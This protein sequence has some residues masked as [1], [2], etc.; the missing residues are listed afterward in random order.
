[1]SPEA[2]AYSS[3]YSDSPVVS[4]LFGIVPPIVRTARGAFQNKT[5]TATWTVG[6]ITVSSGEALFVV[7]GVNDGNLPSLTWGGAT[8]VRNYTSSAFSSGVA[9]YSLLNP[10]PGT[11]S[12]VMSFSGTIPSARACT[13]T[14]VSGLMTSGAAE[15]QLVGF[16]SGTS[17]NPA[18][19]VYASST[20]AREF[21]LA[22][23]LTLG[24]VSD[25]IGTATPPFSLGQRTGTSGNGAAS[26]ATVQ[27]LFYVTNSIG[28]FQAAETGI[29]SRKWLIVE[30]GYKALTQ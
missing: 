10:T 3:G 21:V 24:P 12:L 2:L 7:V 30:Q 14:T 22:G 1:M 13:V 19:L 29:T 8:L 17:S 27:E 5:S 11:K 18:A 16:G 23:V 15:T 4:G 26:N 6:D 25:T 20:Q 28:S 9:T